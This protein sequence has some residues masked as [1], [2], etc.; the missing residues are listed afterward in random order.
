MVANESIPWMM[1]PDEE[2]RIRER[3]RE[4]ARDLADRL[5][6]GAPLSQ[7]DASIAAAALRCWA[8][9]LKQ[10]PPRARG[11]A[12]QFEHGH[13]A[14]FYAAQLHIGAMNKTNA[15]AATAEAYGKSVETIKKVVKKYGQA[16]EDF[17]NVGK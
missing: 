11:Q 10:S 13:A 15:I 12:P 17:V 7:H 9:N 1:N 6:R 8:D 2:T 4:M 16:A 3:Q 14:L 5:E